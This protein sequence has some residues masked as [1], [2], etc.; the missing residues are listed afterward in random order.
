MANT[1]RKCGLRPINQPFGAIRCNYYKA[2]TGAA[3]Y[4]YTPVALNANGYVTWLGGL[5]NSSDNAM[6]G[7]VVAFLDGDWGPVD[8]SYNY[9]P[10][11]PSSVDADGL[12]NVLVADDP[13]QQFVIE[14][15]TGGTALTSA[16]KGAQVGIG[17]QATSGSTISGI[18]NCLIDRSTIGTNLSNGCLQLIK[19]WDKPDNDYGNYAKWVV[20]PAI[21]AYGVILGGVVVGPGI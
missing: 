9:V 14:E 20:K 2:V 4:L 7:S 5:G 12:I 3:Y 16:A 13:Q 15:D 21:H 8:N 18:C 10:A 11:N 6:L 17:L 19:L 1:S